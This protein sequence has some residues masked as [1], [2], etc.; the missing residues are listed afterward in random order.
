MPRL[1]EDG[2]HDSRGPRGAG[3]RAARPAAGARRPQ[4]WNVTAS[5]FDVLTPNGDGV[6]QPLHTQSAC[7][8][9]VAPTNVG[10]IG[11]GAG[12]CATP[13]AL[14]ST[15]SPGRNVDVSKSTCSRKPR[16]KRSTPATFGTSPTINSPSALG[17]AAVQV[18]RK[19]AAPTFGVCDAKS[20]C[21][22]AQPGVPVP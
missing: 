7:A 1:R 9:I 16:P 10:W 3:R 2:A 22:P 14:A 11:I 13:S 8:S 6:A 20:A 18:K 21:A 17:G 19:S 5:P 12:D 4:F 15:S